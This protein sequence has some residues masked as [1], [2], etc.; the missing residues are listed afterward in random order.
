MRRGAMFLSALALLFAGCISERRGGVAA[1]EEAV[2]LWRVGRTTAREVV[3]H[4]GNP[5]FVM[6]DT[7]VWWNVDSLGGKLKVSWWQM[8]VTVANSRKSIREYHLTFGPDG[9]LAAIES[10]ESLPG[11]PQWSLDP[12][13]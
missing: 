13:D 4:W 2:F 7:W 8:G 10:V 3:S 5:D 12:T 11:G 9:R 1:P 6:G